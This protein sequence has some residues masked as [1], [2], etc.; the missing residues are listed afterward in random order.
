[1]APLLVSSNALGDGCGNPKCAGVW[2]NDFAISDQRRCPHQ[3][4]WSDLRLV[5]NDRARTDERSIPDDAAFEMRVMADRYVIADG[6]RMVPKGVDHRAVLNR[7]AGA[8]D[9][10]T[11]IAAQDRARPDRG[12]GADRHVSEAPVTGSPVLPGIIGFLDC[13]HE[14][15][16]AGGDHDIVIGR[17]VAV[18]VSD[19]D[20]DPMVFFRR[21]YGTFAA[22]GVE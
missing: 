15:T 11:V 22:P 5:Q 2:R 13:V 1:M 3:G 12:F 17:V 20:A 21:Q 10:R 7:G 14:T 18:T 6:C 16:Y 9:D 4:F 19:S 8:N